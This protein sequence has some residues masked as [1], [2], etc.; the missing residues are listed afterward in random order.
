MR[1]S[2]P[3]TNTRL[4]CSPM[5]PPHPTMVT[6]GKG[7]PFRSSTCPPTPPQLPQA[8]PYLSAVKTGSRTAVNLY[9]DR[10]GSA[11]LLVGVRDDN[12]VRVGTG[13]ST[14]RVASG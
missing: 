9:G 7:A 6:P 11:G 12:G 2:L 5:G 13:V 1:A 10:V 14:G 8:A 4:S 3:D